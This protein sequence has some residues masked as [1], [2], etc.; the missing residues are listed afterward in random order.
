[1][2]NGGKKDVF[3]LYHFL[4]SFLLAILVDMNSNNGV[5]NMER[6]K[7]RGLIRNFEILRG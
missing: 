7:Q 1:M 5:V 6:K 3:A 4:Q 2:L